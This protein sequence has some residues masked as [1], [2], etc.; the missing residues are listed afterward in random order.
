MTAKTS[1]MPITV[2]WRER[3]MF[4]AMRILRVPQ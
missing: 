4:W 2:I 1:P 3:R